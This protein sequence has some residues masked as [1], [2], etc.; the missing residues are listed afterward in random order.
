MD[1]SMKVAPPLNASTRSMLIAL[2]VMTM[3]YAVVNQQ[4]SM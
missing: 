1:R 3:S 4:I 2:K